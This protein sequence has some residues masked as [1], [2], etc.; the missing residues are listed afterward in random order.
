MFGEVCHHTNPCPAL[1]YQQ[2]YNSAIRVMP[3]ELDVSGMSI[4]HVGN[5][6]DVIVEAAWSAPRRSLTETLW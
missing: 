5:L 6:I 3:Q 4:D 1:Q 2:L